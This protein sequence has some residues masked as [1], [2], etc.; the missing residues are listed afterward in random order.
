MTVTDMRLVI[1]FALA[2]VFVPIRRAGACSL[3]DYPTHFELYDQADLVVIVVP[4]VVP[5]AG[6]GKVTLEIQRVIKGKRS[7]TIT[8]Q[9]TGSD[10]DPSFVV[11]T[12]TVV[13]FAGIERLGAYAGPVPAAGKQPWVSLLERWGAAKDDATRAAIAADAIAAGGAVASDGVFLLRRKA[14]VTAALTSA[15]LTTLVTGWPKLHS[16]LRGLLLDVK[17]APLRSALRM[18]RRAERRSSAK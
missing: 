17:H 9:L 2:L 8:T 18:A 11:G 4:T 14:D 15:H 10:C 13:F 7:G 16:G 12:P 5:A 1:L 3:V 6:E